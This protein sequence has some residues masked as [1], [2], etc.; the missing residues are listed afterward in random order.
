MESGG[1]IAY[2]PGMSGRNNPLADQQP[3]LRIG[4]GYDNHRLVEGRPLVLGGVTIPAPAGEEAHS[5]GDVLIHAIVDALLGAIGAGDIGTHFSDRDPRWKGQA[6]RLFLEEAARLVKGK[7]YRILNLDSTVILEKVRLG[8][9]K[10]AI[11]SSL[12][13]ILEPWFDLPAERISVKA[14]TNERCDA[15]GEGKAVAA[16]ASVLLIKDRS[17]GPGR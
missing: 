15:V 6:S 11:A 2:N 9:W 13:A 16:Q 3:D 17:G 10:S 5:D 12:A 4:L 14:K 7:G 8:E 1:G